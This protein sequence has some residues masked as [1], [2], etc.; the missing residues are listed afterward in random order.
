MH[1]TSLTE[2]FENIDKTQL[3]Q[4]RHTNQH[5]LD[6][7][8]IDLLSKDLADELLT[9]LNKSIE[10]YDGEL[11]KVR[12]FG[13]W[14]QIPRQQSAYGD[15]GLHYK[16][17]GLCLPAKNWIQPLTDVKNLLLAVTGYDYNFVL[18]NKYRNGMDHMGEH[19]DDEAEL[20]PSTP[21]ASLTLGQRRPFIFKHAESRKKSGD[22]KVIDKHKMYLEHGSLLMMNPPTNKYWYHSLPICKT[23]SG[24]RINLTFRRIIK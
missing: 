16:F 10:Y 21:I 2:A 4:V 9:H 20:D 22:K 23:A 12:V 24:E 18:I 11:T 3:K 13:K 8:S 1:T 7:V 6:I 14:H 15:P 5:G 17:S 19:R